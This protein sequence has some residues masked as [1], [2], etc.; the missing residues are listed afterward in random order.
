MGKGKVRQLAAKFAPKSSKT[1]K[2]TSAKAREYNHLQPLPGERPLREDHVLYLAEKIEQGLLIGANVQIAVIAFNGTRYKGNGQHTCAGRLLLDE[3]DRFSPMVNWHE[4]EVSTLQDA[5]MLYEQFDPPMA[6]RSYADL[7][8]I[9]GRNFGIIGSDGICSQAVA[10]AFN[11]AVAFVESGRS[12][13]GRAHM[14]PATKAQFMVER[15]RELRLFVEILGPAKEGHHLRRDPVYA[16]LYETMVLNENDA[17]SFWL[18]VR[19]GA[20]L[21]K[22]SP[23]KKVEVYLRSIDVPRGAGRMAL[24][25]SFQTVYTKCVHAWNAWVDDRS[26]DLKC[27]SGTPMPVPHARRAS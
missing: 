12:I 19:E 24:H 14:R 2:L 23:M 21:A 1:V 5:V 15:K 26:T 6:S 10:Q 18:G 22:D 16:A 9:V 7:V 13:N 11:Q 27:V 25:P 17:Q 8:R 4:Y 3:D 20:N